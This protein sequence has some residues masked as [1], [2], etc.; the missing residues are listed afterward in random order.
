MDG[1]LVGTSPPPP[2]TWAWRT[3]DVGDGAHRLTMVA[4][5]TSGN[6]GSATADVIVR[7][8]SPVPPQVSLAAWDPD[9]AWV[10]ISFSKPMNRSSVAMNL[11]TDPIT[12]H[13]L[14][15][16]VD[17]RC[18]VVLS[19]SVTDGQTHQVPIGSAALD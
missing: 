15:W 6:R 2:H 16:T 4:S 10:E 19:G 3:T 9:H 14:S 13:S 5:D 11:Q 1:S 12:G 7:N 18:V 17:P 8:T